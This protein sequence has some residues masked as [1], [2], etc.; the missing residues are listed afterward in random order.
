MSEPA[1]LVTGGSRGIGRAIAV[2]LAGLGLPVLVNYAKDESAAQEALDAL[3]RVG[4]RAEAM[5]A[6]VSASGEVDAMLREIK[7]MG[8][9]VQVLVNNAGIT[10]DG[11]LPLMSDS[12]W[13]SVIGTNLGGVFHCTRGVMRTM[14]PKKRGVIVNIAS[15]SGIRGHAGQANYSAAKAGVIAMTRSLARELGPF[16][17]RVNAVAPGFI[18]TDLLQQLGA[19]TEVHSQLE[20]IRDQMIPFGRFGDAHEVAKVVRFL[21]SDDASYVNGHTLVVDGGLSV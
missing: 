2:E 20:T 12:A 3:R 6:D 16:N 1:V 10:R 14:I 18:K 21:A 4:V 7:H 19:N 11:L 5:R 15:I 13:E 8:L 17:I 9:W